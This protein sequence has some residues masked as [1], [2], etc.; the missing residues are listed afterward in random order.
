M[1]YTWQ[2][3]NFPNFSYNTEKLLAGIQDFALELG[4]TNGILQSFWEETKRDVFAELLLSEA[5]KTSE[6]EGGHQQNDGAGR[7][8]F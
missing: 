5:L 1:T 6:I 8:G 4:E 2:S 7:R 3:E